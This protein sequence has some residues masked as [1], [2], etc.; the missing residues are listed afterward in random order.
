ML[1]LNPMMINHLRKFGVVKKTN[2][3]QYLKLLGKISRYD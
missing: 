1:E 3:T 2:L